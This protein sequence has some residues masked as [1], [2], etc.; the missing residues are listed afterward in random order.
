M[1]QSYRL[2]A[3]GLHA[4]HTDHIVCSNVESLLSLSA[5]EQWAMKT[6]PIVINL[7]FSFFF[8]LGKVCE[9]CERHQERKLISTY[10]IPLLIL[11]SYP[12]HRLMGNSV[13]DKLVLV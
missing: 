5:T 3:C 10:I 4:A 8:S 12:V 1:K 11:K 9:I 2:R 6:E 7:P 13:D